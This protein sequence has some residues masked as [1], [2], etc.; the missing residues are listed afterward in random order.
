MKRS[1]VL[2][3]ALVLLMAMLSCGA[4]A[5]QSVEMNAVLLQAWPY[6]ADAIIVAQNSPGFG[7]NFTDHKTA[8]AQMVSV[9]ALEAGHAIE[10]AARRTVRD[11]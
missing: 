3:L 5:E 6:Y 8:H 4:A 10:E 1:V 11:A 2:T 9:K 7:R